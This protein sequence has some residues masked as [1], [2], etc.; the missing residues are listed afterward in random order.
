MIDDQIIKEYYQNNNIHNWN[1]IPE[2]HKEYLKN[3]FKDSESFKE[4]VWR[5][6]YHIEERPVCPVCGNKVLFY[7]RKKTI[8]AK[9]CSN[10]CFKKILSK[11]KT[12]EDIYY[13]SLTTKEK[14]K[15]TCRKKYGVDH[16]SQ[17]NTNNFKTNNPQQNKIIKEKTKIIRINKFGQY[18]SP[19]NI[20]VLLTNEIKN[21]RLNSIKKT[22]LERYGDENYR[23]PEKNKKTCLEKY[24]VESYLKSQEYLSN[25]DYKKINE[26]IYLA[27]K[28]NHSFK[29][30]NTEDESYILLKEKYQDVKRQ[31]KSELY[32]FACDFYIPS[33][34]LYIECNYHWT[35][36]NKIYEGTEEDNKLL[37]QWKDN[38]TEY[39]NNAIKTWTSYDVEK[40]NIA[41]Q[42]N[43]NYLIFWNLNELKEW[44]LK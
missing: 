7:G 30:S 18:M 23:N 20:K 34:D 32:P 37:Q 44:L 17:L 29:Q 19:N 5:I 12:E 9:T 15:Y 39:Y 38:N 22:C 25:V 41:K 11:E 31:Y 36:G 40:Y 10:E 8:F 33:L 2:E 28:K 42:N 1:N 26:K 6:L 24:G 21:K 43:L 3:R 4:S 14:T 35:H 27:K 16:P 13:E